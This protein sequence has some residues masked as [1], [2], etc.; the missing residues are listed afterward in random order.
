MKLILLMVAA[1][2][3]MLGFTSKEK[4]VTP[5]R[6]AIEHVESRGRATAHNKEED[7]LGILQIRPIM[8]REVNRIVGR[9]RFTNEDRRDIKKSREMFLIFTRHWANRYKDWSDEGIARR[10]NGGPS[11]H[12]RAATAGYWRKVQAAIHQKR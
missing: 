10:W 8:V 12:K 4:D 7:A 11:G 6:S 1:V 5:V 2:F 9:E 3:I